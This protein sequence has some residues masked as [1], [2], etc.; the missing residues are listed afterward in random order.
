MCVVGHLCYPY[1]V[2]TVPTKVRITTSLSK[3]SLNTK[4]LAKAPRKHLRRM[5]F[6]HCSACYCICQPPSASPQPVCLHYLTSTPASY[7]EQ[8]PEDWKWIKMADHESWASNL[9]WPVFLVFQIL[10]NLLNL[11]GHGLSHLWAGF[12]CVFPTGEIIWTLWELGLRK[13]WCSAVHLMA[14]A[15]EGPFLSF[16]CPGLHSTA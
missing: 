15:A 8:R 14:S 3:C 11:W 9:T 1:I 16:L 7:P 12:N 2:V 5:L 10:K 4:S 6:C 13:E